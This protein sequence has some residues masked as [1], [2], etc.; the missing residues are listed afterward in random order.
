MATGDPFDIADKVGHQTFKYEKRVEE[1]KA[2]IAQT[3]K[4]NAEIQAQSRRLKASTA[5]LKQNIETKKAQTQAIRKATAKARHRTEQLGKIKDEV[6]RRLDLQDRGVRLLKSSLESDIKE[7]DEMKSQIQ[8]AK[9][10]FEEQM[11]LIECKKGEIIGRKKILLEQHELDKA[12]WNSEIDSLTTEVAKAKEKS[13]VLHDTIANENER[14]ADSHKEEAHLKEKIKETGLEIAKRQELN[15]TFTEKVILEKQLLSSI[16]AKISKLEGEEKIA[17]FQCDE[18]VVEKDALKEKSVKLQKEKVDFDTAMEENEKKLEQ[19]VLK[20]TKQT[21]EIESIKNISHEFQKSKASKSKVVEE[22]EELR[23]KI[24]ALPSDDIMNQDIIKMRAT[25]TDLKQTCNRFANQL[26]SKDQNEGAETEKELSEKLQSIMN[27]EQSMEQEVMETDEEVQRLKKL[28]I[29]EKSST[30]KK[31]KNL[32]NL[33]RDV[34]NKEKQVDVNSSLQSKKQLLDS[35]VIDA[36]KE[37]IQLKKDNA[38]TNSD[39]K[40]KNDQEKLAGLE[41]RH[42]SKEQAN[43]KLENDIKR[44]EMDLSVLSAEIA[45]ATPKP[46][47]PVTPKPAATSSRPRR[48]LYTP[49]DMK[50]KSSSVKRRPFRPNRFDSG[51]DSDDLFS[52]V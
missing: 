5:Q 16:V 8:L 9:Q 17:R 44:M 20:C 27:Q 1:L 33:K 22:V 38:K 30:S 35:E 36:Q 14:A 49:D 47:P 2:K 40:S 3:D 10:N 29:E 31:S 41:K 28:I 37:L 34:S 39:K 51:S 18:K 43:K 12:S 52:L 24:G 32:E 6:H 26:S 23:R 25:V 50:T 46:I 42:A 4:R 7:T 19:S 11:A 48:T 15:K 13:K 45:C 21:E